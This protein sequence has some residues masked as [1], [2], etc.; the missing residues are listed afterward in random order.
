MMRKIKGISIV[1]FFISS[2][3]LSQGHIEDIKNQEYL[4]YKNAVNCNGEPGDNL[5]ERICANLGFQKSDS[6]LT[7]VY[8]SLLVLAKKSEYKE[9]T[10]KIVK[11]QNTWRLFRDQHCAVIYDSFEGC[12]GCHQRAID[13]LYCLTELTYNRIK[14][15][16]GLKQKLFGL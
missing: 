13:Y 2:K 14:E 12:G 9:L 11:M 3:L 7:L 8:D 10:Q 16:R 4:K 1:L 15:L 6:L 5:S